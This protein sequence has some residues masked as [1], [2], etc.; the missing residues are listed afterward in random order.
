MSKAARFKLPITLIG[1]SSGLVLGGIMTTI[2]PHQLLSV[3]AA[4]SKVD[5]DPVHVG[6]QLV[7]G[8]GPANTKL[9][10]SYKVGVAVGN[11]GVK[12]D[13]HGDW[14]IDINDKNLFSTP[15]KV[16]DTF[17]VDNQTV[18]VTAPAQ[19]SSNRQVKLASMKPGETQIKGT[20][21]PNSS[22]S[23]QYKSD[24]FD[25]MD[26]DV[27][28]DSQGQ[29]SVSTADLE[30]AMQVDNFSELE[31]GATVIAFD[32]GDNQKSAVAGQISFNIVGQQSQPASS[33][34]LMLDQPVAYPNGKGFSGSGIPGHDIKIY[35]YPSTTLHHV[36]D[37]KVDQQ[38]HW[39]VEMGS[40][41]DDDSATLKQGDLV[42]A[43]DGNQF[44]TG[45]V[46]ESDPQKPDQPQ[47]QIQER[48]V[49][50]LLNGAPAN[51]QQPL[52]IKVL[53]H[54]NADKVVVKKLSATNADTP[55]QETSGLTFSTKDGLEKGRTYDLQVWAG[56]QQW[57]P[58]TAQFKFGD[59]K[60]INIDVDAYA[61]REGH[62]VFQIID[63]QTK[64]PVQAKV[65]AVP[66][67]S[68]KKVPTVVKSTDKDG[69][70]TISTS[71]K[72]FLR[73]AIYHLE[74]S[75]YDVVGGVNNW[76]LIGGETDNK[77]IQIEVKKNSD[78]SSGVA[79]PGPSTSSPT[80]STADSSVGT[81][82]SSSSSQTSSSSSSDTSSSASSS[83]QQSIDTPASTRHKSHKRKTI[84]KV[85]SQK[86]VHS[87]ATFR[88]KRFSKVYKDR[89]LKER[90]KQHSLKGWKLIKKE[91]IFKN[92]KT[93][94]YYQ[95]Q[96][97]QG[98]K[99]WVSKNNLKV[100][101][102]FI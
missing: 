65:T 27:K 45:S 23:I 43:A 83:S 13:S 57:K 42:L 71:D 35:Y 89:L 8:S 50:S 82:S 38:G 14:Q 97:H 22:L 102:S 53:D 99:V 96:S 64:K 7:K 48:F 76:N 59:Q 2:T 92:G 70:V 1:I 20:A 9:S 28:V 34:T 55:T 88:I 100:Q 58:E 67:L 3:Q 10:I 68:E 39:S 90:V 29:F 85:K 36:Y 87:K 49:F 79:V 52:T 12:T 73:N 84:V 72:N 32:R 101:K 41:D 80:G 81:P 60:S 15:V 21:T 86:V 54:T 26:G 16:G 93:V 18:T 33:K 98:Q 75:G 66:N 77:P 25:L 61:Y 40:Q 47:S 51:Y 94:N 30:K 69:K 6:D 24:H 95:L 19:V 63:S 37:A 74:V 11:V 5:I 4:V 17:S 78:Q 44:V 56:K 91:V 62:H 31:N 46:G